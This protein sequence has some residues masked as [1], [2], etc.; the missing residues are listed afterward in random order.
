MTA[1]IVTEAEVAYKS[2]LTGKAATGEVTSFSF[3]GVTANLHLTDAEQGKLREVLGKYIAKAHDV[4]VDADVLREWAQ[5]NGFKVGARGRISTEV[6]D[7]Y[8]SRGEQTDE[9]AAE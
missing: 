4:Q 1:K 5:A 9:A 6:R 8:L 3:E 2:D 7:A